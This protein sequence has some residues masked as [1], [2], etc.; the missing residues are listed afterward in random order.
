[1]NDVASAGFSK[2]VAFDADYRRAQLAAGGVAFHD[3]EMSWN[4]VCALRDLLNSSGEVRNNL[5]GSIYLY[6]ICHLVCETRQFYSRGAGSLSC[7]KFA[8]GEKARLCKE[9]ASWCTARK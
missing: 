5:G 4:D 8:A 1:M 2:L 6:E 9:A 3:E 7:E